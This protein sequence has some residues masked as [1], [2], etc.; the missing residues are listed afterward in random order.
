MTPRRFCRIGAIL[1]S[2]GFSMRDSANALP[3]ELPY[4]DASDHAFHQIWPLLV[5]KGAG[6][7]TLPQVARHRLSNVYLPLI[8]ADRSRPLVVGQLGQSLDGRIAT[9]TGASRGISGDAALDHLHRV[10]ALVDAVVVGAGTVV[11]D[12]PRLT[13]RRIRG[14]SPAR[15]LIDPRGRSSR[16]ARWLQGDDVQRVVFSDNGEGWPDDVVR[17]PSPDGDGRFPPVMIVEALGELGLKKLLIEGGAKTLSHFLDCGAL[18]RLHIT[19]A[20]VILG[21]GRAGLDLR[22]IDLLSEARRPQVALHV[23]GDGN[24][25]YDCDFA[26]S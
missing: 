18:D 6:A 11:A 5:D 24:V 1:R 4:V 23:L 14:R 13:T 26:K 20:P 12:D 17:I 22:P 15:V 25:L 21:S 7:L 2:D 19:V 10:R 9:P 8:L 16:D 3:D